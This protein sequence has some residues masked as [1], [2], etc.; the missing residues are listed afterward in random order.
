MNLYSCRDFYISCNSCAVRH[1]I[2]RKF[3]GLI[4]ICNMKGVVQYKGSI[5]NVFLQ[6]LP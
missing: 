4:I 3:V 6:V 2:L 5:H 1:K